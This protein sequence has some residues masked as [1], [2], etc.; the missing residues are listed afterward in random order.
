MRIWVVT[1][2]IE[3]TKPFSECA[4]RHGHEVVN[5]RPSACDLGFSD[6]G[7]GLSANSDLFLQNLPDVVLARVPSVAADHVLNVIRQLEAMGVRCINSSA[8]IEANRN[9]IRCYAALSARQLPIPRTVLVQPQSDG[10]QKAQQFERVMALVPGAPWILKLPSGSKGQGV[11]LVESVRSL[12]AMLD[13]FATLGQEILVQEYLAGTGAADFRVLV[14]G[15]RAVAAVRRRCPVDEFRANVALGGKGQMIELDARL[16]WL[17]EQAATTF[18]LEIAGVDLSK[19]GDDYSILETN[20]CPGT[21][22]MQ[23]DMDASTPAG[24]V[25][26]NL[27]SLL[28]KYFEKEGNS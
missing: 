28:V 11:M 27:A 1:E 10:D 8:A 14:V 22:G 7:I 16:R 25:R 5:I 19:V 2:N 3:P 17:A 4:V 13:T 20:S 18:G 21:L 6:R 23:R 12:R 24:Q 26:V 9:K 15:G